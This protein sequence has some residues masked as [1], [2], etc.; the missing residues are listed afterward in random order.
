MT[1]FELLTAPSPREREA[2]RLL[3]APLQVLPLDSYAAQKAAEIRRFLEARGMGIGTADYL[4][5]GIVLTNGGRLL[6]KNRRHFD[7]V[8]GLALEDL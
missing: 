7:R 3:L 6:T 8:P 1:R 4:I 2:V 5:A